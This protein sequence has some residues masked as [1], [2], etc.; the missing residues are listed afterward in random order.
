M[1]ISEPTSIKDQIEKLDR[2]PT[3]EEKLA[4]CMEDLVIKSATDKTTSQIS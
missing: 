4:C 2:P 3:P 1:Q